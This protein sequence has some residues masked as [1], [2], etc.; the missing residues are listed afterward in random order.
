MADPFRNLKLFVKVGARDI[1][2]GYLLADHFGW[3]DT[4]KIQEIHVVDEEYM[5]MIVFLFVLY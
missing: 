2:S 3:R 1:N 4:Q 5:C